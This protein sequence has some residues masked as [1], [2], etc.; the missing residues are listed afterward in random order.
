MENQQKA[1]RLLEQFVE[2]AKLEKNA[3]TGI[4]LISICKFLTEKKIEKVQ[5]LQNRVEPL[6]ILFIDHE[7][8]VFGVSEIYKNLFNSKEYGIKLSFSINIGPI[9]TREIF[10]TGIVNK[11]YCN[12]EN[13]GICVDF[14]YSNLQ[15]ED[16]RFLYEKA[17]STLLN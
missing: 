14:C 5:S 16:L 9:N 13:E 4:Q 1:K 11:I 12:E 8:I 7:R 15:E 17:T 6:S 10:V 3:G 2:Q